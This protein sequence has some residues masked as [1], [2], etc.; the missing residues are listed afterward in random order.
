MAED[1]VINIQVIKQLLIELGLLEKCVFCPNGEEAVAISKKII[2]ENNTS[3]NEVERKS[4]ICLML[5]DH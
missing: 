2:K 1:Q 4:P 3:A 5:L